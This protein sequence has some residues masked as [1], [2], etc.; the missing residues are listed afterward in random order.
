LYWPAIVV[1]A[2]LGSG[3]RGIEQKGG[4]I[5]GLRMAFMMVRR[6]IRE[7]RNASPGGLM[8]KLHVMTLLYAMA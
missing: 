2:E 5:G 7:V 1:T 8:V 4:G 6:L 3:G